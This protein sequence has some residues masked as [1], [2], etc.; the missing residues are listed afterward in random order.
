MAELG[1][2]KGFERRSM[3]FE[4]AVRWRGFVVD[5]VCCPPFSAG[6]AGRGRYLG[7]RI[8]RMAVS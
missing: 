8:I 1:H 4:D 6:A 5:G 7:E 3:E 2:L